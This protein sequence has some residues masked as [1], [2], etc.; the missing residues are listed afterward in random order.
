[1]CRRYHR[2]E[3]SDGVSLEARKL[4]LFCEKQEK[5]TLRIHGGGHLGEKKKNSE[6]FSVV[7][8]KVDDAPISFCTPGI[9]ELS[10]RCI[11]GQVGDLDLA[12]C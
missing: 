3:A 8:K 1:M 6:V 2:E 10:L 7:R 4:R 9:Q 5:W 11:R 12:D